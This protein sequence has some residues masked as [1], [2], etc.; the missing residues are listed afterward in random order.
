MPLTDLPEDAS[1]TLTLSVGGVGSP[2]DPITA[3]AI[4]GRAGEE[5][6]AGN[7]IEYGVCPTTG[8][9]VAGSFGAESYAVDEG[10]S[11]EVTVTLDGELIGEVMVPV[12]ASASSAADP[13]LYELSADALTFAAGETSQTLTVT[14]VEN[15]EDANPET[16][17]LML[18]FGELPAS[19][20]AGVPASA[21]VVI[22]D[23]DDP[24]VDVM[25]GADAYTA[26]EGRT[27]ASVS[28]VLSAA[29]ERELTIPVTATAQGGA[30]ADDYSGVP[31]SLT[32]AAEETEKSFTVSATEEEDE[33]V[34]ESLLLGFGDLPEMVTAGT[35]AMT[36]VTLRDNDSDAIALALSEA[37]LAEDAGVPTV[38]VTA[39]LDL[40]S[41]DSLA[42]GLSVPLTFAGTASDGDDY[43]LPSPPPAIEF[44]AGD[45][46][47]ATATYDL[48]LTLADDEVV[49]RDETIVVD[50]MAE[51]FGVTPAELALTDN[52]TA[53]VSI[54]A[55]AANTDEGGMAAFTLT[56][57]HA[58][59]AEVTVEW[60]ATDGS[61]T[62]ADDLDAA[63][64]SVTFAANSAAEATQSAAVA[65][66]DDELSEGEETFTVTLG[67]VAAEDIAADKLSVDTAAAEAMATIAGSD[68]LT[69]SLAGPA[70]SVEGTTA[71]YTLSVEGGVST[72]AVTATLAAGAASTADTDDYTLSAT[73]VTVPA[74][75]AEAS[76]TVDIAAD[77]VE[78]DGETLVLELTGASGGGGE[79]S[80]NAGAASVTTT[81]REALIVTLGQ[82]T[83]TELDEGGTLDIPVT[84]DPAPETANLTVNYSLSPGSAGA[85]DYEDTSG[86]SI[87]ISAGQAGGTIQVTAV[88]D[89]RSEGA[90]TF[91]VTLTGVASS[92]AAAEPAEL[93]PEAADNT[94]EA[95]ISVSDPLTVS[96][97]GPMEVREGRTAMYTLSLGGGV[98]TAAVTATLAIA[99]ASTT[100]ADDHEPIPTMVTLPAG[101]AESSFSVAIVRDDVREGEE[102]LV[103]EVAGV[104]GGGGGGL[105]VDAGGG[106]VSTTITELDAEARARAMKFALA[107]FGRT[108]AG[109][110]VDIVEERGLAAQGAAGGGSHVT[111]G[112]R[113]LAPN[114]PRYGRMGGEGLASRFPGAAEHGSGD[115]YESRDGYAARD[116]RTSDPNSEGFDE[117]V[118]ESL[119]SQVR[120]ATDFS[121]G[122]FN[123]ARYGRE[124]AQAAAGYE[125]R[126]VDGVARWVHSA[127]GLLGVQ[128]DSPEGLVREAIGILQS[129]GD[130]FGLNSLPETQDLL[131]NSSFQL[132][133]NGKSNAAAGGGG[134]GSWTLWG[135]GDAG[136]FEGRPDDDFSMDGDVV[137]AHVGLDFR[138]RANLLAGVAVSRSS[139]EVDYEFNGGDRGDIDIE[140]TSAHP[141][142]HWTPRQGLSVWG[143]VG[144]GSGDAELTDDYGSI[145][146]D[147][148]MRMA[149]LGTR[150]ELMSLGRLD[151]ALKADAFMVQIETDDH[152]DLPEVEADSSRVRVALEGRTTRE[153]GGGSLLTSSF[154]LGARVDGGDA[155]TGAGAELGAGLLFSNPNAGL[156]IEA[157]GRFLLAH[158]ESDFEEWGASLMVMLDPGAPGR[159]LHLAL[160]PTWGEV[161]S[162]VEGLW[163][164]E[165]ASDALRGG[166]PDM[167]MALEARLGYGLGLP[168]GRGLL[169]LFGELSMPDGNS[170]RLRLGT[171]L[172]RWELRDSVLGFE[173]YGEHMGARSDEDADYRIVI[174][175]RW[176]F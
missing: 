49:E 114:V 60:S 95:T 63:S 137:A 11:V 65:V 122:G 166:D 153:L 26:S 8:C 133:L 106:S 64:G 12:Q 172:G 16:A 116:G 152:E 43:T 176:D 130:S 6:Q 47:G 30:T 145:E 135:R 58:V 25:F 7:S 72:A 108:V 127:A 40:R 103:L 29:P 171:E 143:T 129:G 175:T 138:W 168:N 83:S 45:A 144:A 78:D 164:S 154:E 5:F 170:P 104:D 140:L 112:G 44:A 161:S 159:G 80:V 98:S 123:A 9:P 52:D 139:G 54:A 74:G 101:Q 96:L 132:A 75:Q 33:D 68:P 48:V 160:M 90:E 149:A 109:N 21:T 67:A 173:L 134:V 169:T 113:A 131:S 19:V 62:V 76:V 174:K 38:T 124:S 39:T 151:L 13:A 15:D 157:R 14:A 165:R 71:T 10:A 84:V 148:D 125:G 35:L 50:A 117:T 158:S 91:S 4:H 162:G 119:E 92:D 89:D 155:E 18:E 2:D 32:F 141:Y 61:A 1:G 69:V 94:V 107:G 156:N 46:S 51:G 105:S 93:S 42:S 31:E 147:I 28:V 146:T 70:R 22:T 167:G 77:D 27:P 66:T 59:D 81:L 57:S 55:P 85:N 102:R 110:V 79:I 120:G 3:S 121:S 128:L 20:R 136:G 36:T 34:G 73:T 56:L 111:L 23:N 100:D 126:E 99:S 82:P 17:E 53:T 142:L 163:S 115:S 150:G 37:T 88:D 86:G 41:V 87:T 118:D 24:S 97:A